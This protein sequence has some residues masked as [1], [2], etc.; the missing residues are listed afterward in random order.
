MSFLDVITDPKVISAAGS[1]LG[2]FLGDDDGGGKSETIHTT[3]VQP[4]TE[5][6]AAM[7]DFDILYR[8]AAVQNFDL[9]TTQFAEWAQQDETFMQ[10]TYRP[11]QEQLMQTNAQL[12]PIIERT[13]AA[14]LETISRDIANTDN[15]KTYLT[16]MA[17]NSQEIGRDQFANLESQIANI[18]TTEERVGQALTAVETQF[19]TAGKQL[20]R[21]F[22]SRGQ[23][24]TQASKRDLAFQKA[25]AKAGAA[26]QAAEAARAEQMSGATLGLKAA[27]DL[28]TTQAA[29]RQSDI[30]GLA[31][32]Q[33]GAAL[34]LETPQVGGVT[35][36]DRSAGDTAAGL[37][38]TA[39]TQSFGTRQRQDEIS[40][41]Q[42][43]IEEAPVTSGAGSGPVAGVVTDGQGNVT[44]GAI[45]QPITAGDLN[46]DEQM[47]QNLVK[48]LDPN[49]VAPEDVDPYEGMSKSDR[50]TAELRD[51][52]DK[53]REERARSGGK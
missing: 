30:S 40:H 16:G 24:V 39:G 22:A 35:A 10:D 9:F 25:Q 4:R 5:S 45:G 23:A 2:G 32:L 43:G 13:N 18:P 52:A 46:L 53:A 33:Q 3:K 28:A 15:L 38:E 47:F 12:L 44:H 48:G 34:G 51:A 1:A 6:T 14:A 20:A 29:S 11:F 42:K 49:Y 17:S 7:T 19:S 37:V 36:P 31:Q 41:T 27:Q 50:R 8:D 26:G 21:D